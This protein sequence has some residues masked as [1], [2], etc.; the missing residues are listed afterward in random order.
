MNMQKTAPD[1]NQKPVI[2]KVRY[3]PSIQTQTPGDKA[4]M[5]QSPETRHAA[6]HT[7]KT[8]TDNEVVQNRA[9]DR[10]PQVSPGPAV[11][12]RQRAQ[13]PDQNPVQGAVTG[14]QAPGQLA[15]RTPPSPELV[16]L[17]LGARLDRSVVEEVE[18]LTRGQSNNEDWFRWRKNR[19]TASVAHR[20]AHCRFV[21]GKSKTPPTSYLTAITGE[22]PR[23]QTRAMSWGI[24]KEAEVVR[25]YQRQKTSSGRPVQVL[26][27]GLFIDDQRPWLAASPDGIVTDSRTG[28]WL[29]CL[30]VK[31][32]Y[33]HRHGRV[34][35][36]CRDDPAF[37]LEIR[38]EEGRKPGQ[39]PAYRL[40][41][42]HS[43][44]TQIQC[45]LAVTGLRQADLVVFTLKELGVVPVTF[46]PVFWEDTVS[47]LQVFYRDAV[48]PHLNQDTALRPET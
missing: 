37:C 2:P 7:P 32:P 45:Q 26:D 20:I 42:S 27:C 16:P 3:H 40:K 17:V 9:A 44:F 47:K 38:D 29:L 41:T 31:C 18:V 25:M 30:E 35:D 34:E 43:Y 39:P 46:D 6:R 21:N 8:G 4:R 15:N 23:V 22:G 36:A 5:S 19:I 11:R 28:Q 13:K 12:P 33:K 24:T 14:P 10:T 1:R 48:L